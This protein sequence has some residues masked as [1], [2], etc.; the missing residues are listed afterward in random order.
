[1]S[2]FKKKHLCSLPQITQTLNITVR[3]VSDLEANIVSI[4]RI[5]E[6]TELG[7]E[8]DWE[9]VKPPPKDW[10]KDGAV[11]FDHYATRYREGLDLVLRDINAQVNAGEKVICVPGQNASL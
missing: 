9:S 5:K 10:P 6:Y 11:H 3:N 1:M 2:R 8:A 7:S 4:E